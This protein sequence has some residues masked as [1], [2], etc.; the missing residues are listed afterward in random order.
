[1]DKQDSLAPQARADKDLMEILE[2]PDL[3]D[4][5]LMEILE[6]VVKV[7]MLVKLELEILEI[8]DLVVEEVVAVDFTGPMVQLTGQNR[9]I[10]DMLDQARQV[11]PAVV[12][13]M[14]LQQEVQATVA[15][16][17]APGKRV[18]QIPEVLV[19]VVEQDLLE[20]REVLIMVEQDLMVKLGKQIREL[21]V[22]RDKRVP[23]GNLHLD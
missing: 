2:L 19:E 16:P 21:L 20:V 3:L 15:A 11:V 9:V 13:V 17:A 5:D 4:K 12:V 22:Q 7:E 8:L 1:M 10:L 18:V 6:L 14:A 23:L